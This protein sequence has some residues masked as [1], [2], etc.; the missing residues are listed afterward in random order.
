MSVA[1]GEAEISIRSSL[2]HD[3][4]GCVRYGI[5]ARSPTFAGS[6]LAWGNTDNH[7][8]LAEALT[9]FPSNTSSRLSYRL[10]TPGT[11]TCTLEF[12][13]TDKLGHI[14]VWASMEAEYPVGNDLGFEG[15]RIFLRCE[16]AAIDSFVESLRRFVTGAENVAS[17]RG[18][19]P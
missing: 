5:S 10:G 13:C 14:G 8:K 2:E 11:G 6:A 15:A 3:G 7:L 16:P 19:G 18:S 4:D 9:G 1:R 17:L 12:F